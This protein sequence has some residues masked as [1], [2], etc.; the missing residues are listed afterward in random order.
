MIKK[1]KLN[2]FLKKGTKYFRRQDFDLKSYF[3]NGAIYITSKDLIKK[4][5]VIDYSKSD[6]ILM[7]KMNSLDL[8]DYSELKLIKSI[9]SKK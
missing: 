2:F 9:L 7:N 4:G 5:K 8:N 6:F 3:I 1:K